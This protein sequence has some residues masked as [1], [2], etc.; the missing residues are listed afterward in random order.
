M[1]LAGIFRHTTAEPKSLNG[2]ALIVQDYTPK[3]I[4]PTMMLEYLSYKTELATCRTEAT[5][6]VFSKNSIPLQP[7]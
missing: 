1:Q 5:K 7:F 3:V 2:K 6:K 4:A